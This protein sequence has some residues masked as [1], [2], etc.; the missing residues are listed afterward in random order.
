V[1]LRIVVGPV[2]GP[3]LLMVDDWR[4]ELLS[5]VLSEVR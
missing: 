2:S 5:E 1:E 3:W 4:R